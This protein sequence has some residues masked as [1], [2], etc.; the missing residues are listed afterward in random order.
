MP[1]SRLS[2]ISLPDARLH[3]RSIATRSTARLD[4][5]T[6][7]NASGPFPPGTPGYSAKTVGPRYNLG[8]ARQAAAQYREETGHDLTFTISYATGTDA[9]KTAELVQQML[10]NAG[11]SVRLAA[12]ADPSGLINIAIAR[13]AD[14]IFWQTD[15]DGDPDLQYSMWH[16]NNA[17]PAP[18][19]NPLNFA[20]FNDPEIN[21][22]LDK[23]RAD[24]NPAAPRGLRAGQ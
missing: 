8:A 14:A 22:A 4:N 16:C 21:R 23:G 20:G 13:T 10:A 7:T 9:T 11:I 1:R 15:V 2:I 19:D 6:V 18:C 5:G 12:I 3:T 24:R 17:P